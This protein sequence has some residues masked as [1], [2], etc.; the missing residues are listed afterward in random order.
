M[1]Q[2]ILRTLA[3]NYVND[4]TNCYIKDIDA[5]NLGKTSVLLGAGRKTKDDLI[6]YDA[7]IIIEKHV[8]AKVLKG[9]VLCTLYGNTKNIN[10]DVSKYFKISKIKQKPKSVIIGCL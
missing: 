6:N 5:L 9:D 10:T 8:T 3:G 2:K 1:I 7:G 4:K